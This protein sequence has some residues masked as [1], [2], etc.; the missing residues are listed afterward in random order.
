MPV[1]AAHLDICPVKTLFSIIWWITA[2]TVNRKCTQTFL[3]KGHENAPFHR[4]SILKDSRN[5]CEKMLVSGCVLSEL[6]NSFS[7]CLNTQDGVIKFVM[8][9]RQFRNM[10]LQRQGYGF[11]RLV[12][13]NVFLE[14]CE[15]NSKE[16]KTLPTKSM[17][18]FKAFID[19]YVFCAKNSSSLS[20]RF[21]LLFYYY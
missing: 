8:E 17:F 18:S 1:Y 21:K 10:C 7:V 20:T 15:N 5:G 11:R 3:L 19:T 12:K 13:E 16:E 14:W 9:R 4:R 2:A 6:R